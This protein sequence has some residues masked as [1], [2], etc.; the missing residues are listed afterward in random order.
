[1]LV[2]ERLYLIDDTYVKSIENLEHQYW[3]DQ[4]WPIREKICIVRL[5]P[6]LHY[7]YHKGSFHLK[8]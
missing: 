3:L 2:T 4:S 6:I 5:C 1:M 8:I 7:L